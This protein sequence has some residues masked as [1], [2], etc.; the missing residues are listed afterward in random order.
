MSF[1]E[2][3]AYEDPVFRFL[4]GRGELKEIKTGKAFTI[5]E[6]LAHFKE[7]QYPLNVRY[8]SFSRRTL[9]SEAANILEEREFV[10]VRQSIS[11]D[12]LKRI[13]REC[14]EAGL[15]D[16]SLMNA[17]DNYEPNE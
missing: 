16:A 3:P 9:L 13:I 12:E 11:Q 7:E 10:L 4:E 2:I 17:Y 14:I 1:A 5:W 8:H 15:L 6:A